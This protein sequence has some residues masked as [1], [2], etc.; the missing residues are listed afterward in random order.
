MT[1]LKFLIDAGH[2]GTLIDKGY[3]TPGK[4]S[5]HGARGVIY[6]G[7]S[8]R[9]FAYDLAYRLALAGRDVEVISD[10]TADTALSTRVKRVNDKPGPPSQYLLISIH[11]N[12]HRGEF[13]PHGGSEIWTS[14]GETRSDEYADKIAEALKVSYPDIRWRHSSCGRLSKEHNFTM[15]RA[16]NCPAVLLEILFMDGRD[17]YDRLTDP[18][19]RSGFI[20]TLTDILLSL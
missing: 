19:W 9:A 18:D 10:S 1:K 14:V 15:V 5:P 16:T 2:G 13:G 3:V 6:E 12:A 20:S 7:V 8:N 17:D 4:R 11:S